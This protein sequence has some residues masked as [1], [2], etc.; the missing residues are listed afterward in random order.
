MIKIM[1]VCHGNICR[2]PMAE[3]IFKD[4]AKKK[5][6]ADH[7]LVASSA[8]SRKKFGT[9]SAIR[10]IRRRKPSLK[11]M[12]CLA[13]ASVRCSCK[14]VTTANTICS[15][16]CKRRIITSKHINRACD[17]FDG[18]VGHQKL[19]RGKESPAEAGQKTIFF[20]LESKARD[21][22]DCA[23]LPCT[24]VS[25]QAQEHFSTDILN[26]AAIRLRFFPQLKEYHCWIR[27]SLGFKYRIGAFGRRRRGISGIMG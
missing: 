25:P 16:E 9:G 19:H 18:N 20:R 17:R 10:S 26:L 2:S 4:L 22:S 15:F 27:T 6:I 8:T 13:M 21:I 11:G 12:G 14:R 1:F 3:F 5:G 7:F 24:N 23:S